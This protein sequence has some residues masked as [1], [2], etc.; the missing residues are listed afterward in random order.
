MNNSK[1]EQNERLNAAVLGAAA[2]CL[3]AV[4]V[5]GICSLVIYMIGVP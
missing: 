2:G 3:V 1:F 4:I 5:V